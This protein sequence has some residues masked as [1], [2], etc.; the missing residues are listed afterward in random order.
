MLEAA[1]APFEQGHAQGHAC[2][3]G[4]AQSAKNL[5][6]QYGFGIWR[7]TLSEV[8]LG[9]GRRM[10]RYMPQLHERLEG[11]AAGA[12]VDVRALEL[13]DV[14]SRVAGVGVAEAGALEARLEIPEEL[15]PQLLL[16]HSRP[17]A[18][19]FASLELTCAAFAGCLAGINERGLGAIVLEDRAL[20]A[21]SLRALAQD[22][23]YRR[24][25]LESGVEHLKQRALY[26]E[27]TGA[28]HVVDASG[29]ALRLELLEG[30]LEVSEL[31]TSER[32]SD[33]TLRLDPA[34]RSIEWREP[35][36]E[37]RRAAHG[38]RAEPQAG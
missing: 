18:G 14:Q 15:E 25:E 5:R 16:R 26:S 36:G 28:L 17:D 8:H 2:A 13:L 31:A 32:I 37:L 34:M 6:R 27:A 3:P 22:L 23:I 10:R 11:I 4:I 30:A 33:S 12:N 20:D 24:D 7:L 35:G 1:G 19:G 21:P 29:R 9:A 38:P